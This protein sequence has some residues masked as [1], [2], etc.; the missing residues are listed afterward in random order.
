MAHGGHLLSGEPFKLAPESFAL[1]HY[2]FRDQA[3]AYRKY[4]ERAF[5]PEEIHRGWHDNRVGKPVASFAFPAASDLDRLV[6][7][8]DR[9][10]SRARPRGTH[11]WHWQR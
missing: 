3:H 1:R 8:D 11:Y 2:M 4:A 9:P 6:L 5:R 7:P 10:L